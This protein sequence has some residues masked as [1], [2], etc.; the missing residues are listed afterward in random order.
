MYRLISHK[1][2]AQPSSLHTTLVKVSF[3][4][5]TFIE[6]NTFKFQQLGSFANI[7][8][9]LRQKSNQKRELRDSGT[10]KVVHQAV[11]ILLT[12]QET[13]KEHAFN[14]TYRKKMSH[15]EVDEYLALEEE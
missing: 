5:V 3:P 9:R 14:R 1:S 13:R 10:S 4:S 7:A 6:S 12:R 8:R 11:N 15:R 2:P